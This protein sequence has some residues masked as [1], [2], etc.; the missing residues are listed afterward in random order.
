MCRILRFLVLLFLPIFAQQP[1]GW[2]IPFACA[3]QP[4]ISRFNKAFDNR[5]LPQTANRH[6]GWGMELRSLVSKNILFGPM[7]FR[8]WDDAENDTFHLRTEAY[9]IFGEIGLKLPLFSFLTIV[10]LA[11]IGGVQPSFQIRK[12]TGD[13]TLDSLLSAPGNIATISPGMKF[14]GLGALELNLLLPTNTGSYGIA[15][16][17][18]YLYSPLTLDWHLANGARITNTPDSKIT[19]PWFSVGITI[20]PAPE[21]QSE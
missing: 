17:G 20:I 13:L 6:Y 9:G 10:P 3:Y 8:T 16:R 19:G 11:G 12:V 7:F 21:I 15:L 2:F 14:T 5:G 1:E 4:E 18:G